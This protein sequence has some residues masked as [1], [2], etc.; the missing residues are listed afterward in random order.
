MKED[1]VINAYVYS[2]FSL[3]VF[4]HRINIIIAKI[5]GFESHRP[6]VDK[7]IGWACHIHEQETNDPCMHACING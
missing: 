3:H 4:E 2:Y 1:E 5:L 6:I 7:F